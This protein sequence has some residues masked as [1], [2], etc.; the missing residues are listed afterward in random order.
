MHLHRQLFFILICRGKRKKIVE[1]SDI[2]PDV[3]RLRAIDMKVRT[4]EAA[5]IAAG[6][7]LIRSGANFSYTKGPD[8]KM[9][10]AGGD[11]TIDTSEANTPIATIGK[12]RQIIVA[13]L[14]PVDPSPQ[15][16]KVASTA[17]MMEQRARIEIIKE[18]KSQIDGEKNYGLMSANSS[19]ITTAK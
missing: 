11:V 5:H 6:G 2:N 10:A 14:A 3:K 12:A 19:M 4:H 18:M 16:Y 8:G 17:L 13:A 15:D 9:Y 1:K 7:G